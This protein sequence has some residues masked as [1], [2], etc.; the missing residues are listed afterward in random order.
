MK[1]TASAQRIL[2]GYTE[3]RFAGEWLFISRE[4]N[5]KNYRNERPMSVQ[6]KKA[7]EAAGV[8]YLR[9]YNCRHSFASHSIMAGLN[10]AFVAK[11]MGDR[12]E[13]VLANYAEWING[14]GDVEEMEK[15][16]AWQAQAKLNGEYM[17]K[18]SD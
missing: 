16:N 14:V 4:G 12:S 3:T 2:K 18:E 7:C 1:L 5:G 15:L 6:F 10:P 9:P 17:G 8:R 11:A 13:T